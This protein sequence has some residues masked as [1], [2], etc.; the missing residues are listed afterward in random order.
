MWKDGGLTKKR[1]HC[2][3]YC[4]NKLYLHVVVVVV[5]V[6]VNYYYYVGVGLWCGCGELIVYSFI[7]VVKQCKTE[8]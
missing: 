4:S 2:N 6:V 3:F 7:K 5:V 1:R 8:P